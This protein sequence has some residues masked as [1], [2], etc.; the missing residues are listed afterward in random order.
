MEPD[1]PTSEK[2]ETKKLNYILQVFGQNKNREVH[3]SLL[4]PVIDLVFSTA[5]PPVRKLPDFLALK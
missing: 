4:L 5:Q 2:Q 1:R 3:T